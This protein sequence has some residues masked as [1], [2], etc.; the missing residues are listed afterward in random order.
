MVNLILKIVFAVSSTIAL[1][2]GLFMLGGSLNH[3][4]PLPNPVVINIDEE[5]LEQIAISPEP[6][7]E[8]IVQEVVN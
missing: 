4:D 6:N 7:P 1:G 2:L 3:N 5:V 8:P